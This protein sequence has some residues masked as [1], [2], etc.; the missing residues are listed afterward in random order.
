MSTISDLL[1]EAGRNAAAARERSGAIW[2]NAIGNISQIPGQVIAAQRQ[3]KEADSRL[4]TEA[5]ARQLQGQQIVAGQQAQQDR[6]TTNAILSDTTIYNPDGTMNR[7]AL[8]AKI[9]AHP[10]AGSLVPRFNDFADHLE[11]TADT[12]NQ[13]AA[14]LMA[15]NR[16]TLGNDALK[17]NAMGNDPGSAQLAIATRA[18]P[19]PNGEAPIIPKDQAD[20]WLQ[21]AQT[22]E[23]VA[24]L[25]KLW[26]AGTAAGQPKIMV[27]PEGGTPL[28]ERTGKPLAGFTVT[29][30]PP[31]GPELDAAAQTIYAKPEASRTP[32]E[33]ASLSA[34]EQRKR[35]VSDPA[36]LAATDRQTATI[37]AQAA[38]QKRAQ[39]FESLK[40]ARADIQKNADTPFQTAKSSAATLRDVV[41]AAQA[42]NKV[43][44]SLQSLE[45][46]MAAIRAQGLNRINR[47]ETDMAGNAGSMYDRISGWLGKAAEGQPVPPAVQ[48]D[49][50]AFS[51]ILENAAGK[52]YLAT[53]NG[54]NKLYGTSIP[55][56]FDMSTPAGAPAAAAPNAT[57]PTY[58][59]YL[60]SRKPK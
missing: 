54:I 49:M 6:Q 22:S 26:K 58:Q 31:T 7:P 39:D 45:A 24:A 5:G 9:A 1:I 50:L 2:G 20:A 16:E 34:Y 55:P 43:A 11:A 15:S 17:I 42:G 25:M 19:G 44:G 53:H 47:T 29:P 60:N 35:V 30:K 59:D 8:M 4:A 41:T 18:K 23:G 21:Q 48:K 13:K 36:A 37:G 27:V 10:D 40:T 46:T 33:Q 38:Q 14:S 57:G 3:T 51:D 56:T 52:K 12:H 32:A 28:D